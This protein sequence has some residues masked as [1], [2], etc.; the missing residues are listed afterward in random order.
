[1]S[2]ALRNAKYIPEVEAWLAECNGLPSDS[3]LANLTT[4][5]Q[6][7]IFDGDWSHIVRYWIFAQENTSWNNRKISL[8]IPSFPQT[9]ENGSIT[10]S[11]T[12]LTGD[13]STGYIDLSY[14][15]YLHYSGAANV[16]SWGMGYY[17]L[18]DGIQAAIDMGV[19]DSATSPSTD[20]YLSG[21]FTGGVMAGIMNGSNAVT[22]AIGSNASCLAMQS[23]QTNAGTTTGYNRG[24]SKGTNTNTGYGIPKIGTFLMAYNNGSSAASF[25]TRK[26]SM[27]F[28]DDGQANHLK[29]YNRFQTFATAQGFNI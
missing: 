22:N 7:M 2:L 24:V 10:L 23:I 21:R 20:S 8:K 9:V 17:T 27:A 25:T 5:V 3:Y 12:G 14:N 28:I 15:Q 16:N 1:M 11:T 4:L 6:G 18:T 29:L 26:Y 13:G 19:I